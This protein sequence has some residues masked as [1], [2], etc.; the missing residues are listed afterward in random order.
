MVI[1][2]LWMSV[3][4]FQE[5]AFI[6]LNVTM[7]F[8][9]SSVFSNIAAS[10]HSHFAAHATRACHHW[11]EY[12]LGLASRRKSVN[13]AKYQRNKLFFFKGNSGVSQKQF[14]LI[15][16]EMYASGMICLCLFIHV[17]CVITEVTLDKNHWC[18]RSVDKT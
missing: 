7:W 11:C 8:F 9:F 1:S 14:R 10:V 16:L 3:D 12:Q 17:F 18:A 5:T 6:F 4:Y 13:L 2:I 15:S